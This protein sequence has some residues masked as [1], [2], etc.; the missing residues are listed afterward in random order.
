[1]EIRNIRRDQ[2]S[3]QPPPTGFSNSL[4]SLSRL[5]LLSVLLRTRVEIGFVPRS[6]PG[7]ASQP[8]TGGCSPPSG[9]FILRSAENNP[10][11]KCRPVPGQSSIMGREGGQNL[12]LSSNMAT[13]ELQL[14]C[15]HGGNEMII[16]VENQITYNFQLHCSII[17]SQ[18]D[19]NLYRLLAHWPDKAKRDV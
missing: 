7:R 6:D 9:Q 8:P 11:A 14:G 2:E 18:D 4:I 5:L 13:D 12:P 16:W 19:L 1:M 17:I 10:R 15:R 3:D